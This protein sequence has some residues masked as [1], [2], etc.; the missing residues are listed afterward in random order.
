MR[1]SPRPLIRTIMTIPVHEP[2][3]PVRKTQSSLWTPAS[4]PV[5]TAS[6]SVS[7][8]RTSWEWSHR[9]APRPAGGSVT[10]IPTMRLPRCLLRLFSSATHFYPLLYE[11]KERSRGRRGVVDVV[12]PAGG[13]ARRLKEVADACLSP[14]SPCSSHP[15]VSHGEPF[16]PNHRRGSR[17]G[18]SPR[19]T[20]AAAGPSSSRGAFCTR[21]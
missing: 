7:D 1:P 14:S 13:A 2:P 8:T 19:S 6:F 11:K 20:V 17:T 15:D 21:K 5:P 9:A 4:E 18:S 12:G 3:F 10:R 16:S